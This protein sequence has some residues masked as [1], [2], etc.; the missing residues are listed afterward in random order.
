MVY[1]LIPSFR[2]AF[3]TMIELRQ[4]AKH[5]GKI[6]AVDGID[7]KIDREEIFGLLGPNGAGKTTT[8]DVDHAYHSLRWNRVD[9]RVRD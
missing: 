4:L 9:Q 6:K 5:Y 1:I 8:R 7:L 3:E 2:E